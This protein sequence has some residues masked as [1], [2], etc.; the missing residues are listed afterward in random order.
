VNKLNDIPKELIDQINFTKTHIDKVLHK[1]PGT[2]T[3]SAKIYGAMVRH[4]VIKSAS[5]LLIALFMYASTGMSQRV[6][7]A[8]AAVIGI[9]NM[10]DQ[11]WQKK[12]VKSVPWLSYLLKETMPKLSEQSRKPFSN[13]TINLLDGSMIKQAGTIGEKGGESLRVHMSYNLSLGRMGEILVTDKHI[14][15][16]VAAFSINPGEIYIADAGFGKGVNLEYIVSHHAEALFRATPNHLSLAVDNKGKEKIDMV[17]KLNTAENLIDFT[18]Y[19]HTSRN[20]YV[21]VR[22]IA[23]RLPEDKALLAKERKIHSAKKRQT[24]NIRQE[25]LVY[26]EWV[27][28]M[29]SLGDEYSAEELLELYRSRWQIELLFKRI[30]QS[31]AISKLPVASLKHST[32]LVLLWLIL[33]AL[34]EQDALAFE[35]FLLNK[36]AD[37]TLYSPWAMH[38][39]L[40]NQF[41]VSVNCLC[42]LFFDLT[43]HACVVFSRLQNHRSSRT[44]HYAVFHFGL[45]CL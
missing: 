23:S 33:W 38:S 37:M 27:I 32:A 40:F 15:E 34:T 18:C 43:E 19:V 11:A 45:G 35:A 5:D 10:S 7:S 2:L 22:I 44:N 13:R 31:F 3:E 8:C 12:I 28:L 36:E 24:K 42:S 30:K 20:K 41:K 26:A 6:L 9:G 25:T 16:S 4:R 14:A 21:P 17:T 29:T 39:F 1:I